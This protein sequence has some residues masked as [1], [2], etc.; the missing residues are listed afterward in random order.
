LGGCG[1]G[2]WRIGKAAQ[3]AAA[4][5]L[6]QLARTCR[7]RCK[8][9]A[10]PPSPPRPE[11]QVF[12]TPTHLCIVME[13]AAGGE[14]FDRIVKAGR[15]SE[16]EA[17][18]FFQQLIC[19]VDYCHRSV[20]GCYGIACYFR[21]RTALCAERVG[22][23]GL[24]AVRC[25]CRGDWQRAV[26]ICGSCR[27]AEFCKPTAAAPTPNHHHPAPLHPSTIQPS[28]PPGRL[29]P[30]PQAGEHASGRQRGAAAQDLRLWVQQERAGQPAEEHGRDAGLH[31]AR[32]VWCGRG[33]GC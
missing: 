13:Y 6:Q 21:Q 10:P 31:R 28:N 30:R 22:C 32:G 33:C 16:D 24:G 29:P 23:C 14:L 27:V 18:Y 19:G 7:V 25:C 5:A 15:F 4:A 11:P 20:S 8:T 1:G 9:Q 2:V 12:L 3:A 26:G 17:R